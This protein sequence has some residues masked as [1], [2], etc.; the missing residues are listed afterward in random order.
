MPDYSLARNNPPTQNQQ[1]QNQQTQSQQTQSQQTQN[2]MTQLS[3]ASQISKKEAE[4]ALLREALARSAQN[5]EALMNQFI[6]SQNRFNKNLSEQIVWLQ[7]QSEKAKRTIF[8]D[9]ETIKK[10]VQQGEKNH[11]AQLIKLQN[12]NEVFSKSLNDVLTHTSDKLITQ[13]KSDTENAL[14][15][16]ITAITTTESDIKKAAERIKNYDKSL[17]TT[18]DNRINT[19]RKSINELFKLDDFRQKFFWAGMIGGILTPILLIIGMIFS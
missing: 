10:A 9:M 1:S 7:N 17:K 19:Y 13:V 15:A 4:I 16:T 6:E 2:P 11:Q 3:S 5:C 14:Q 8:E 12:M 18:L